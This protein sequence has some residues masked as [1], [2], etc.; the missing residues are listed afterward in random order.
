MKRL[1]LPLTLLSALAQAQT[2]E[3]YVEKYYEHSYQV[4][5][6]AG[7]LGR[8]RQVVENALYWRPEDLRW[9]RRLVDVARWQGDVQTA[10]DSWQ[11]IAERTGDPEAWQQVIELAPLAYDNTLLLQAY[12]AQLRASP[13]DA[14]LI[15]T[16]AEQYE[17]LGK[18]DEGLAFLSDWHGRYPGP[19][20][21]R[22]M[23]RLAANMGED[24]LAARYGR[25]YMD[26][27]GA[28][29]EMAFQTAQFLWR[30]G[31][32]ERA[33]SG[34]EKDVEALPYVPRLT[35]LQAVMASEEG[36]WQQAMAGY[37]KLVANDDDNTVDLYQYISLARYHDRARVA[38]LMERAWRKNGEQQFALGA[39][40]QMADNQDWAGIDRFLD[41]LTDE[42]KKVLQ[43][44][45]A[46]QRFYANLMLR[47]GR[48]E[49][50]NLWLQRALKQAPANRETRIAWL[51]LQISS[52]NDAKVRRGLIAWED[53]V[54]TD[55]RYWEVL[56]AAHMALGDAEQSLRY[57]TRLLQTAP[58]DWERQ[59]YYAQAL[60]AAGRDDQ[61]WSV[62]RTLHNKVPFTVPADKQSV[63]RNLRLTLSQVFADGDASLRLAR[64]MASD[65][66]MPDAEQ[67]EWLAQWAMGHSHPELAMAWY[68]EKKRE[69]GV[70]E[71]GSALAYALLQD[72]QDSAA[73]VSHRYRGQLTL[74]E[75]LEGH[76][77]LD[78]H[79]QA[80]AAY[81]E[82]QE[83]APQ[84]AGDHLLQESLLLPAAQ[85]SEVEAEQRRIGALDIAD[86]R[87]TQY[88]PISDH[89]ELAAAVEYRQFSSN[90][91]TLLTV[92]DE[93]T[94][95]AL[96]WQTRRQ[97]YRYRLSAG[98]RSLFGNTET[99][100]DMELGLTATSDWSGAW[101]YQW[102]MPADETSLLMLGGSRTG[103]QFQL[104][105]SPAGSW[106]NSLDWSGYDYHDLNDQN[107]GEGQILNLQSTWR[108]WLSRF[109]PGLKL[110]HTRAAFDTRGD[111][112]AEIQ[113]LLPPGA[114]SEPLPQDYTETEA[115]LLL[116]MPD[117]HIRPHRFQGWAELGYSHNSIA[118]DGFVGRA[119]LSGPLIGRDAWSLYMERQLNTGGNSEDSYR[120]GLQYRLYY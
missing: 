36:D 9:R 87:F 111:S 23:Q 56:A 117:V 88:Q 84:L 76:V 99:M 22:E 86:W 120:L 102:R 74:S 91:D 97:Q 33:L 85:S 48:Y 90:D 50:A 27:Y 64:Q 26:R 61:A 81:A 68:V 41:G 67:A 20:A 16:I 75:I 25:E 3:P 35:R 104:N 100:A 119:G 46:F 13:R 108:P 38:T 57:E 18:P 106:Q 72:D 15:A 114:S 17:L 93:E 63:Y 5:V 98:Q 94:R 54:R 58:N 2:P 66:P 105:W 21:L 39:L 8:A 55:R 77:R 110:R 65:E 45:A 113:A 70:L 6:G 1:V 59:W 83:G 34:L 82:M 62:L 11:A 109:S 52:G 37:R 30:Q 42:Q 69:Q 79:R 78:Q 4:F 10:L 60:L 31:E 44:D 40:Y 116:G 89:S 12:T 24:R 14:S 49:E 96:S 95:F 73:W 28:E 80:L 107:L 43:Q 115:A 71:A 51:W 112:M 32:R 103:S 47:E 92:D 53:D 29:P 101:R 7:N 19:A 118:G